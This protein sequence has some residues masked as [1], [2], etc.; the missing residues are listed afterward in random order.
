MLSMNRILI[1]GSAALGILFVA[2]GVFYLITPAES[3]P[4][5]IPG[6]EPGSAHI[7]IKHG[8]GALILGLAFFAYAWFRGGP[9][10]HNISQK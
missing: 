3:L 4:Q 2:L 9:I 5:Y 1:F 8:I 7:H 6:Y 10:S